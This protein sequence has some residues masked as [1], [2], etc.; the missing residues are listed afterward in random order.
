MKIYKEVVIDMNP[1]SSTY[2]KHLS[3]DSHE[4]NGK[5]A[6]CCGSG[7]KQHNPYDWQEVNLAVRHQWRHHL[8]A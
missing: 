1:E 5:I 8:M 6:L 7:K 3:E 2:E 4:Y